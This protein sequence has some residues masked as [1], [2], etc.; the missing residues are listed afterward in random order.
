MKPMKQ[1]AEDYTP[2][3]RWSLQ[4]EKDWYLEYLRKRRDFRGALDFTLSYIRSIRSRKMWSDGQLMSDEMKDKLIHYVDI[5]FK[6]ERKS[7]NEKPP[8]LP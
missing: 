1:E 5:T 6:Q 8:R 3:P 4:D 7:F 2:T